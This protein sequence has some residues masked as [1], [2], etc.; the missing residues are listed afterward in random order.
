MKNFVQKGEV[1]DMTAPAGGVT[2]GQPLAIGSLFG[3]ANDNIAAGS[4]FPYVI[5]GVVSNLP[6]K[7]AEAW[8]EGQALYWDPV[9]VYLT[10]TAG[11]LKKVAVA[12]VAALAADT[13]GTALLVPTV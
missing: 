8:A 11:A 3:I 7:P 5:E 1:L 9:N 6:K 13:V 4:P 12:V 10:T 2:V